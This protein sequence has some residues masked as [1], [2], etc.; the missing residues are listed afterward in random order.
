MTARK[1]LKWFF[2][3]L[4]PVAGTVFALHNDIIGF[5][6]FWLNRTKPQI[7]DVQ[8]CSISIFPRDPFARGGVWFELLEP[9]P[10]PQFLG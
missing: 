9:I 2:V 8:N 6:N 3:A 4:L 7:L 1:F 5:I 10:K